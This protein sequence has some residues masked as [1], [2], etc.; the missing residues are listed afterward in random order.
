M[1]HFVEYLLFYESFI[2]L[3]SGE[4]LNFGQEIDTTSLSGI[5]HRED[6]NL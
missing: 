5:H 1:L 4:G 3:P 2:L 6:I